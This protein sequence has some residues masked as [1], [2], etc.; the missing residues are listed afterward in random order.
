VTETKGPHWFWWVVLPVIA[1]VVWAVMLFALFWRPGHQPYAGLS[2]MNNMSQL[3]Q[4]YLE[5]VSERR[6]DPTLHGSAQIL[7]WCRA[8]EIR[9]GQERVYFCPADDLAPPASAEE[10]RRF[11]PADANE[12]SRARGLG[13]Y[14]VR[15]FEKFPIDP[16]STEKQPI[17][18]DRQGDDGRTSHHKGFI[19]I[20]FNGGDAQ[21]MTN[22]ELG[23]PDGDPIVVGP[24]SPSP[25]LRVFERP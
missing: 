22:A 14:A 23:I 3:V 9:E 11:H 8:G 17:L 19:V 13:S 12:L 25:L 16:K 6:F 7:S 2:C 20:A 4:C 18:C 5:S 15:D 10:R 1:I 21:K 24:D